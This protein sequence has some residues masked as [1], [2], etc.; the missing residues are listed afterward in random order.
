M[1]AASAASAGETPPTPVSV[2]GAPHYTWGGGCDGWRLVDTPGLSV[3]EERMPPGAAEEWHLH[4]G[5][6]QFF[7]VLDGQATMRTRQGETIVPAGSGIGIAPGVPH[8]MAN[9]SGRDL[10][11]LVV[12]APTTRGDRI[13]YREEP[14]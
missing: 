1:T 2:A 3:I 12:S 11:F 13:P 5:A 9:D 4:A 6:R 14:S 10:R 7:Y 8:Q